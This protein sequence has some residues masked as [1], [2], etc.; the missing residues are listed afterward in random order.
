MTMDGQWMP[1]LCKWGRGCLK[2]PQ[3]EDHKRAGIGLPR[4]V[5]VGAPHEGFMSRGPRSHR[6]DLVGPSFRLF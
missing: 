1:G 2:M 6:Q 5:E 4:W 3:R